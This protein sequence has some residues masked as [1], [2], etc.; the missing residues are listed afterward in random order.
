ML[1]SPTERFPKAAESFP[2]VGQHMN[3]KKTSNLVRAANIHRRRGLSLLTDPKKS[4][5]RYENNFSS[6][7]GLSAMD[8]HPRG[9]DTFLRR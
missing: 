5:S 1:L 8:T 2:G 3:G 6:A 9:P 7:L 4:E